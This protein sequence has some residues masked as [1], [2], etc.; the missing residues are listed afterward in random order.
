[1]DFT[2]F[3]NPQEEATLQD[4]LNMDNSLDMEMVTAD[5]GQSG[6]TLEEQTDANKINVTVADFNTPLVILFGPPACGKTM[7]LVRLTRYL[8]SQGYVVQP[9]TSFRPNYDKN[10]NEL[11][12]NFDEM[13][14]SDDAAQSTA[15]I[16]F[17]LVKVLWQGRPICQILEGPGEYYFDPAKPKAPFPNYVNTII[18]S[19]NRK[20]WLVMVEPDGTNR[21]MD[22]IAR[23]NYVTKIHKL[24]SK[25]RP[26]DKVMFVFN[27]VDESQFIISTGTVKYGYLMR[28]TDYLYPNIFI[29]FRNVNP[30]TKLWNPYN[31]DFVAFQTGDFAEANDGTLTFQ[32]GDEVYPRRLWGMI[33]KRLRG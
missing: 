3:E 11:C 15:K 20:L 8:Q 19:R 4:G 33:R 21:R 29:P 24:K 28:H 10:Y 22:P 18:N 6:L 13:I 31:F 5:D 32:A 12:Q 1:M 16:N 27:K 25:I 2:P 30:I 23:K 14:N 9:E 26:G 7:T 17:M